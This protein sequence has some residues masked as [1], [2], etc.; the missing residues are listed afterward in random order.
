MLIVWQSGEC[1]VKDIRNSMAEPRPP[2]TTIASVVKNLEK[3]GYVTSRLVGNTYVYTPAIAENEY[4]LR[5]MSGVVSSYF[6][7]SYKGLVSFFAQKEKISADD[8]REIIEMIEQGDR[9]RVTH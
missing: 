5:F 1:I 6:S 3:K 4:K 9:Q 8:L 2:Y 7:D